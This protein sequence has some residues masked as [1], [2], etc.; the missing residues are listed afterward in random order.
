MSDF[1]AFRYKVDSGGHV[2]HHRNPTPCLPPHVD[3]IWFGKDPTPSAVALGWTI[4]NRTD[5]FVK[6]GRHL[7]MKGWDT[8]FVQRD[9]VHV[10][11]PVYDVWAGILWHRLL[12]Q[13]PQLPS[14]TPS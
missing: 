13:L 4:A 8:R 3:F 1:P 2:E 14:N 7:A 12:E 6:L 10:S 9:Q 11:A 5:V